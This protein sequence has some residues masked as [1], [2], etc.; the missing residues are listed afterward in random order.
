MTTEPMSK[1]IWLKL[2]LCL[3]LLGVL[4]SRA[5]VRACEFGQGIYRLIEDKHFSL[6]MK[7]ADPNA[8]VE[9]ARVQFE[10]KGRPF[11]QGQLTASQGTGTIYFVPK[12]DGMDETL[13][14]VH[15]LDEGLRI[16]EEHATVV[17]TSGLISALYY[18]AREIWEKHPMIGE[19]WRWEKC[20]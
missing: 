16:S 7:P 10:H 9:F 13:V 14:R 6:V 5:E 18:D 19:V 3:V 15:F 1:L 2:F 20:E 17:I 4:P 11:L 12:H 8:A